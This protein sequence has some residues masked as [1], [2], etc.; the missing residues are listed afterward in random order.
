MTTSE[1][2]DL[3]RKYKDVLINFKPL[4]PRS[5]VRRLSIDL[6]HWGPVTH[7]CVHEFGH[8]GYASLTSHWF[9]LRL[10]DSEFNAF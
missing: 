6:P 7:M 4:N 2:K 5:S 8:H 1:I 9:N 10:T 3:S